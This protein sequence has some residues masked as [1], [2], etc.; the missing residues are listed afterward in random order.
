[1]DFKAQLIHDIIL[2]EER[3]VEVLSPTGTAPMHQ[4][5]EVRDWSTHARAHTHT[6]TH[7][8]QFSIPHLAHMGEMKN[9]YERNFNRKI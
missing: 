4:H 7:T 6:H 9:S 1:M 8:L 5:H 2:W 3:S